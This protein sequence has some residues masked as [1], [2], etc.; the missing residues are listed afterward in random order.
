M[1]G[2]WRRV[3]CTLAVGL[4]AMT[5]CAKEINGRAT[6]HAAPP[7]SG[8]SSSA[9][10][11]SG[12]TGSGPLGELRTIDSCSLTDPAEFSQFGDSRF[13]ALDSLDE[14]VVEITTGS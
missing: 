11:P 10:E 3:T 2:R 14:C 1:I 5:G 7:R 12:D 9:P 4:L 8:S 13:G 6:G